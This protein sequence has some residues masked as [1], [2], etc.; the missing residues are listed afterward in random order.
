MN[1]LNNIFKMVSQLEK[2]AEEVKLGK[3]EIELGSIQDVFNKI[4]NINNETKKSFEIIMK[5]K[6]LISNAKN[7]ENAIIKEYQ[8]AYVELIKLSKT[9]KDLGLPTLEIDDKLKL[10]KGYITNAELRLKNIDTAIKN[11]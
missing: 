8:S 2:N 1:K 7:S 9:V 11:L 4:E 3:H 10:V 6:S 5:A